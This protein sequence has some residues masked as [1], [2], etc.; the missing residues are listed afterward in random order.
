VAEVKMGKKAGFWYNFRL[1]GNLGIL[2]LVSLLHSFGRSARKLLLYFTGRFRPASQE[3]GLLV[4]TYELMKERLRDSIREMEEKTRQLEETGEQLRHSRDFLQS[5][6][7]SLDEELIVLDSDL[8]ITDVNRNFRVKYRDRDTIGR[9]CYEVMY[10]L[11][12]PCRP[13]L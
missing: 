7:D 13:P 3:T 4:N 10:G 8:L 12:Q 2:L 11:K 6:I 5:I 1:L 9:H